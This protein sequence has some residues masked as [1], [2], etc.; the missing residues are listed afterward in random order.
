MA[1]GGMEV[2]MSI[3][4]QLKE[5]VPDRRVRATRSGCLGP[6]EQGVSAVVYPDN[7]WYGQIT[8]DDVTE[9]VDQHLIGGK[10]VKRL[11]LP[12]SLI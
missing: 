11:L 2:Y 4:E 3:R 1:R 8:A 6:C 7:V 12:K 9:I 10:P 5:K